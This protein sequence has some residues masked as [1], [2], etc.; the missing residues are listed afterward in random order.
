MLG[1]YKN[2]IE[3]DNIINNRE[4]QGGVLGIK[5]FKKW[6]I[7]NQ[8]KKIV[9][10]IQKIMPI[11][12][13]NK[14]DELKIKQDTID[15]ID[16]NIGQYYDLN[17]K[18]YNIETYFDLLKSYQYSNLPREA[19]HINLST[20]KLYVIGDLEGFVN[21]LYGALLQE[22]IINEKLEWIAPDNVYIV[23]CG[24]QLDP[25]KRIEEEYIPDTDLSVI[26][27]M[28]YLNIIS[29]GRVISIL[30]N[31]E[32]MNVHNFFHDSK[33]LKNDG[34]NTKRKELFDFDN[35]LIS[36]II[37]RRNF[38]IKI[39]NY[40]FCHGGILQSHIKKY[41]SGK[42]EY[43][44]KNPNYKNIIDLLY[45]L[46]VLY[47]N[48]QDIEKELNQISNIYEI[49]KKIHYKFDIKE[50]IYDINN[51]LVDKKNWTGSQSLQICKNDNFYNNLMCNIL[52]ERFNTEKLAEELIEY[53]L[54][55]GH[56]TVS[57][58]TYCRETEKP[59]NIRDSDTCST[60][61]NKQ[62]P[63]LIITDVGTRRYGNKIDMEHTSN[64][65][66]LTYLLINN[67]TYTSIK[68]DFNKDK[69]LYN[70]NNVYEYIDNKC[71]VNFEMF[72]SSLK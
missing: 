60:D 48:N 20:I 37:K 49:N 54:I 24:D 4:Q 58:I 18:N 46:N 67:N 50:F 25:G 52:W 55:T 71:T 1:I 62:L 63:Q 13:K 72:L 33:P 2:F 11:F 40:I 56:N 23:Q 68:Y 32:L 15:N 9:N 42:D 41:N 22:K 30:G 34:Y 35:G 47:T 17:K 21:L 6:E 61:I 29:K 53:I 16:N 28:D 31:H 70:P 51:F 27:F 14:I 65:P 59:I 19:S 45:K 7:K 43:D 39:N 69:S 66:I 57:D 12:E 64:N 10:D 26:I 8:Y 3:I 44:E 36:K 38:V 5:I